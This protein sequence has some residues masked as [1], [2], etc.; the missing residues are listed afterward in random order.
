ADVFETLDV[1]FEKFDDAVARYGMYKYQHVGDWYIITCPRAAMPFDRA[2]QER[3]Y[4]GMYYR[5][6]CQLASELVCIAKMQKIEDMQLGLKVGIHCGAAAGAVIGRH[7]SFYC[8][9][10][11]TTNTA[12]R[13]C[14]YAEVNKI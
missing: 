14:K 4:P 12:A 13:M 11:D 3:P 8:V 6:M 9:Y 5:K 1:V 7:R 10:G 2:V